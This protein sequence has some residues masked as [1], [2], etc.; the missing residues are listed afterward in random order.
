MRARPIDSVDRSAAAL[1]L[2]PIHRVI[3]SLRQHIALL[4][5]S[6]THGEPPD[7][8]SAYAAA[9][10]ATARRCRS[11]FDAVVSGLHAGAAAHS[12]VT[13]TRRALEDVDR[14]LSLLAKGQSAP[15]VDRPLPS[16]QVELGP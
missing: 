13:D 7:Q 16:Q 3:G 12:S 1:A 8:V 2:R 10:L 4:E 15:R 14:I 9:F 5:V 11:D 6:A